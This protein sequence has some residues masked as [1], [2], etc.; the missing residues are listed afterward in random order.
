MAIQLTL[1][2]VAIAV[3]FF[4][5]RFWAP[6]CGFWASI[7]LPLGILALYMR[8]V[9][10]PVWNVATMARLATGIAR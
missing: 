6:V 4:V 7:L 10:R 1:I 2:F 9:L 3:A 5:A 8:K